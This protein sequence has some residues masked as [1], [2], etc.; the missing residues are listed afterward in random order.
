MMKRLSAPG[1]SHYISLFFR[2]IPSFFRPIPSPPVC[3]DDGIQHLIRVSLPIW[4]WRDV[5]VLTAADFGRGY[6]GRDAR[7]SSSTPPPDRPL[8]LPRC[9]DYGQTASARSARREARRADNHRTR[10]AWAPDAPTRRG[11][12]KYR[13]LSAGGESG[14]GEACRSAH[15]WGP[16]LTVAM[17]V[18]E[19]SETHWRS[20]QGGLAGEFDDGWAIASRAWL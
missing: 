6:L 12:P 4:H 20:G 7:R 11:T 9:S 15:A 1:I 3:A 2:P 8:G 19:S 16:V 13:K 14:V 10:R 17:D 18:Q 5:L